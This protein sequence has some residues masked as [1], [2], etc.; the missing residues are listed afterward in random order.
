VA[1][2]T[3]YEYSHQIQLW[4]LIGTGRNFILFCGSGRVHELEGRIESGQI[5]VTNGQLCARRHYNCDSTTIQLW[6]N[7]DPTT[8]YC[9]YYHSTRFD[10]SKNMNMSIFRRSRIAVESDVYRNFDH[11]RRIVECV[12]VSSCPSRIVVESQLWYKLNLKNTY[13]VFCDCTANV[14]ICLRP[15]WTL[16]QK[17][18]TACLQS[19][20]E[21]LRIYTYIGNVLIAI[22]PFQTVNIYDDQVICVIY[23]VNHKKG[24]PFYFGNKLAK[25]WPNFTIFGRNVA[26]KICSILMLC[27]SPHLFSVVT[28]PQEN[29]VP[30]N[31]VCTCESVPLTAAKMLMIK[32]YRLWPPNSP[33][34]NPVDYKVWR[35]LQEH[36]YKSPVKDMSELKQRL[37]EAWSAMPHW[38]GHR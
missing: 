10:A 17:S 22:N 8:T 21:D 13:S 28:L 9:D 7:Y 26:E 25:C 6:S 31:Y 23:T 36:V 16:V 12:V 24:H 38:R 11:F 29:T 3:F 4:L 18:M 30:F 19:R 5:K 32:T 33:D 35:L 37:V 1:R 2:D 15:N 14:I 20:Y 27:C 34:L